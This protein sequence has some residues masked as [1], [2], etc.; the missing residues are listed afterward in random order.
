MPG[1]VLL[2]VCPGRLIGI[3]KNK[4]INI[5]DKRELEIKALFVNV[6]GGQDSTFSYSCI[7]I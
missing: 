7:T 3:C 6:C 4:Q 5:K 2:N 1:T